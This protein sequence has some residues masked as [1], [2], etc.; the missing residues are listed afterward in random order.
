MFSQKSNLRIESID[1]LR[2][3][4]M[5]LMALDHTR[6]YFSD[7]AFSPADLAHTTT[8]LFLTRWI[9]HF[10][11]PIF[12]FLIGVGMFISVARGKTKQQISFFLLTRGIWMI[13]AECILIHAMWTFSFDLRVQLWQVFWVIGAS[14]I[15]LSALVFLPW[16]IIFLFGIVLIAGHNFL[17]GKETVLLGAWSWLH[18]PTIT[19]FLGFTRVSIPYTIL[20]W[21][22]VPALGYVCGYIF[23]LPEKQRRKQLFYVG[24]FCIAAF[25]LLRFANFYGDPHPWEMQKNW[26]FTCLSFLNCT[27]YP[28]SLLYLLMTLGGMFFVFLWLDK[29]NNLLTRSLAVFG[30]VPFFYYV[31]HL[32]LIHSLVLL[33]SYIRF[34]SGAKQFIGNKFLLFDPSLIAPYGYPLPVVYLVWFLV[35]VMLFPLCHWYAKVKARNE[36]NV[37]LSYV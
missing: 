18:V 25:L 28:P 20:P 37:L 33:A 1:A 6:D 5:V 11:A 26:V 21:I 8:G 14:M 15:T 9:T 22:G 36:N 29:Y 34:G 12:I 35:V 24:T 31:L 23:L 2:G 30:K 4:V 16:R 3:L 7:F 32:A 27:K 17:D 13:I 19:S 10:C